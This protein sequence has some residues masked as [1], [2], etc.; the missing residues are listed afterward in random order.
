MNESE[1]V[2]IEY[3]PIGVVHSPNKHVKGA[4]I[5]PSRAKGVHG[6][7]EVFEEYAEALCDLDGFS[8]VIVL[9]HM[10]KSKDYKL[11]V[12]PFLDN[13]L[14][15]LFATRAPKRPNPIGLSVVKLLGIDGNKLSIEGVDMLD[16]TPVLDI[17]P[18]VSEFDHRVKVRIGWL[19]AARKRKKKVADERFE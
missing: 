10:H 12:V 2:K 18:Y 19:E 8:H 4:P 5:Q 1:D 7:V 11:K 15:G 17:K 9:F 13:K 14:R 6:T 16:K 3:K